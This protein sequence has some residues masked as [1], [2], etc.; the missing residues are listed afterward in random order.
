MTSS[1]WVLVA[2]C[3]SARASVATP[4]CF[5]LFMGKLNTGLWCAIDPCHVKGP[6]IMQ[7]TWSISCLLMPW[8]LSSPGPLQHTTLLEIM[9]SGSQNIWVQGH[10]IYLKFDMHTGSNVAR[11]HAKFQRNRI[12]LTSNNWRCWDITSDVIMS[13]MASQNTSVSIVCSSFAQVQ[14]KENVKALS[15]A[16]VRGIHRWLVVPLTK[17]Q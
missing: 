4:I 9:N 15:L 17:G 5:Q 13:T 2:W 14:I 10:I 7:K 6:S 16:F 1:W 11:V 12:I 8:L 3:F